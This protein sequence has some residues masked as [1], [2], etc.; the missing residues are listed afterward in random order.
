LL[1]NYLLKED[2]TVQEAF[3]DLIY[4]QQVK[5]KRTMTSVEIIPGNDLF[6]KIIAEKIIPQDFLYSSDFDGKNLVSEKISR[7]FALD[8]KKFPDLFMVKKI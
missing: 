6:K 2:A 5:S 7:L 8:S 4:N 1:T 3:Q